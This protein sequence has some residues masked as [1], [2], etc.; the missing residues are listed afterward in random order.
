MALRTIRQT[1]SIQ[2]AEKRDRLLNEII[3]WAED[4]L[5]FSPMPKQTI[6]KLTLRKEEPKLEDVI[7]LWKVS[8]QELLMPIISKGAYINRISKIFGKAMSSA[9]NKAGFHLANIIGHINKLEGTYSSVEALLDKPKEEL[10]N[11]AV[12][13]IEEAAKIKAKDIS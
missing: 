5:T 13:I 3:E 12:Q 9:T 8:L 6:A 7:M 10:H 1:R 4:I 2:K 11:A